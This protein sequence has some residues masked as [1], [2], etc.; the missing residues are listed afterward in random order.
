MTNF[1]ISLR[2]FDSQGNPGTDVGSTSYIEIADTAKN[3]NLSSVIPDSK[4]WLSD[5]SGTSVLVFVHGFGNPAEKVVAR[6]NSVKRH[7]PPG[8]ALVSFDW[9]SG[10]SGITAKE[11]YE[12][13]KNNATKSASSL[14]S[15]CLQVL[16]LNRFTSGNVHLFAHSMGAYVTEQAFQAPKPIKIN[17]VLMAAA[18]VD[19]KNYQAGST[20]LTNFLGKCTDLTAYWSSDDQALPE[21]QKWQGY[22]PLGLQG[23]PPGSSIPGSCYGLDCTSYFEK[24]AK[25]HPPPPPPII[26]PPEFSHVW[27]IL[28]EPTPPPVNDFYS[29]MIR[30]AQGLPTSATRAK[31]SDPRGFLLQRP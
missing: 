12:K 7:V 5:I 3:Y 27:Y 22:V 14:M 23:Y 29:D 18:D 26:L 16:L 2:N 21:S 19:Q 15:D 6:H 10:N 11:A 9:P 24:Y 17:H 13:D 30:T 31:T 28:F 20:S 25:G 8:V 1:L 4:K